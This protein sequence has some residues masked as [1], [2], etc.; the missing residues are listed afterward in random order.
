MT[1]SLPS[2]SAAAQTPPNLALEH[3]FKVTVGGKPLGAF[4]SASGLS[5]QFHTYEYEEGGNNLFVHRQRGRMK[6]DNLVLSG[7]VT[8]Q[9]V[10][11]DWLMAGRSQARQI[12]VVWFL[13]PNTKNLRRFAFGGAAPVRWTGPSANANANAIATESLEIAHQGMVL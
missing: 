11:L 5:A 10:L 7:G 6:Y 2:M 3:A 4:T 13:S 1:P 9:T 8:D 12:V